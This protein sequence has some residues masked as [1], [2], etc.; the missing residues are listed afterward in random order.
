MVDVDW[1]VW[2][3]ASM[4]C[5]QCFFAMSADVGVREMLYFSQGV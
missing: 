4:W 2:C 5:E 3:G 1:D